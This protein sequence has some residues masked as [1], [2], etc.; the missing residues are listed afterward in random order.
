MVTWLRQFL[1]DRSNIGYLKEINCKIWDGDYEKSGRTY[2]SLGPIY[3][4]QWRAW[5]SHKQ[6]KN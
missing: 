5:G 1:K 3:G 2:V 4:K 6:N